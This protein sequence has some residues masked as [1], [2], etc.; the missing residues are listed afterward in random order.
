MNRLVLT[1]LFLLVIICLITTDAQ[2][3]EEKA[4]HHSSTGASLHQSIS[5][6][7]SKAKSKLEVKPK[8]ASFDDKIKDYNKQREKT[9]KSK[10][11][12]VK[13]STYAEQKEE[14]ERKRTKRP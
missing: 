11:Q 13:R 5:G 6:I 1:V 14:Y 12:E 7:V 3:Q 9:S 2:S 4:Q 8:K 10:Y